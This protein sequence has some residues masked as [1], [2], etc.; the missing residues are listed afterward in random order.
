MRPFRV[1][2]NLNLLPRGQARVGLAQQP[3]GGIFEPAHLVGD[4]DFAGGGEAPQLSDFALELRDGPFEVQEVP[5]H[6][7][8]ASGCA[9]ST[10]LRNRSLR[11]CV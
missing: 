10:S 7:R 11:T 3:V 9:V 4:V 5:H 2:R 8:R 1:P 6:L